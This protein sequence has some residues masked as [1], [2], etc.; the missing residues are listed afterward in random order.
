MTVFPML[1]RRA[2]AASSS[3]TTAAAVARALPVATGAG[4]RGSRE[5]RVDRGM[6][7][8]L[9]ATATHCFVGADGFGEELKNAMI[10]HLQSKD[11][12]SVTDL[13]TSAYYDAAAAV[14]TRIQEEKGNAKE[15]DVAVRG[16][17]VCGTGMGVGI[18]ANKHSGVM[19]GR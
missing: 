8:R 9:F 15:C 11:G 10:E 18:L 1:L 2:N 7:F 13:G 19:A 16:L 6:A 4:A 14:A 3:S 5:V 12:V 17:L